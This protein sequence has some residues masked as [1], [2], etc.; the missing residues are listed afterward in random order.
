M[1]Q[2]NEDLNLPFIGEDSEG[3]LI[4]KFVDRIVPQIEPA[5]SAILPLVYVECI[6]IALDESMPSSDRRKAIYER[7]QGE[8]T[9]P[10]ARELN[11][12]VDSSVCVS[13][14]PACTPLRCQRAPAA[15]AVPDTC[16]LGRLLPCQLLTRV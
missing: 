5:L 6:K 7:M 3:A 15:K 8:L 13:S 14:P 12:R 4:A 9:E 16:L 1:S 10:L 11:A 2:V